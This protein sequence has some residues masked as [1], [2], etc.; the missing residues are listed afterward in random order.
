MLSARSRNVLVT[1][2]CPVYKLFLRRTLMILRQTL[3]EGGL[4]EDRFEK[5]LLKVSMMKHQIVLTRLEPRHERI[6]SGL[7]ELNIYTGARGY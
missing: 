4:P 2:D 3:V 5:A 1:G 6:V 7:L